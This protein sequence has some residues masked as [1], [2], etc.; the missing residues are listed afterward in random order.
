MRRT[1]PVKLWYSIVTLCCL[2]SLLLLLKIFV[3]ACLIY[4]FF[5]VRI[6]KRLDYYCR[7]AFYM[8]LVTD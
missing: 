6:C 1:I 2:V 5:G 8:M 7:A 3:F 4:L